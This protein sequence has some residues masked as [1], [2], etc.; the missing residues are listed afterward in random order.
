MVARRLDLV[1][2][3]VKGLQLE[4]PAAN[5]RKWNKNPPGPG[6][7]HGEGKAAQTRLRVLREAGMEHESTDADDD[8]DVGDESPEPGKEATAGSELALAGNDDGDEAIGMRKH[9]SDG[10]CFGYRAVLQEAVGLRE[11]ARQ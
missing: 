5:V 1:D 9:Y 11:S 6:L 4:P 8:M 2:R 7:V 3:V 10:C